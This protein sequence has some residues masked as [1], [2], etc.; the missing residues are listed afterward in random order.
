MDGP[1]APQNAPYTEEQVRLG[2]GPQ[3]EMQGEKW[4]AA[5]VQLDYGDR[6]YV[7]A[8]RVG[9]ANP[10]ATDAARVKPSWPCS[11]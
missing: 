6:P 1:G 7:T 5:K 8:C 3:A 2:D 11:G 4:N 10:M 9:R